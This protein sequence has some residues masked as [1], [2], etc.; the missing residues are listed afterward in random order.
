MSPRHETGLLLDGKVLDV[1][2]TEFVIRDPRAQWDW[3]VLT[4]RPD[5]RKRIEPIRLLGGHWTAGHNFTGLDAGYRLVTNMKLRKRDDDGDGVVDKDDPFADVSVNFGISWDGLIFQF[6]D[7]RWASVHMNR[8]INP[9]SVGVETMSPGS[10]KQARKLGIEGR[11][12]WRTFGAPSR[13]VECFVPSVH[14]LSGWV[15]LARIL[16]SPEAKKASEGLLDIERVCG[17]VSRP[18][19]GALEHFMAPSRKNDAGGYL[20]DSLRSDGWL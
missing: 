17:S 5:M 20:V 7:L 18:K 1:P 9:R 4:D 16:T 10:A 11:T 3:K 2:G 6:M 8:Y 15:T 14:L 19:S 12:E 13:R